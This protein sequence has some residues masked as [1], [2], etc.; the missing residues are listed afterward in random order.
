M[1]RSITI[2]V[3][4]LLVQNTA[5]KAQ[6]IKFFNG[7]WEEAKAEAKA[8]GKA[9][10]VDAYTTWCGPC[11]RMA[12]TVFTQAS[13]GDYFNE[14]FVNVKMDMEKKEGLKFGQKYPVSAYPTLYF[15]DADGKVLHKVKGGQPADKF[16]SLGKFVNS[17]MD[18]SKDYE[19]D[20]A[21]GKREPAFVLAYVKALNKAGKSSLKVANDY[22]KGQKDLNTDFNLD[23]LLHATT[24]ADSR[25]F[26]LLIK[27]RDQIA[28]QHEP[29]IVEK[30]IEKACQK[31]AAKAIE[32]ESEDL[33]EEAKQKMK[34]HLPA[35][36]ASFAMQADLKYYQ[37][38]K[39]AKAFLK[40]SNVFV[41]K[42]V[43]N[44]AAK[45]N[46]LATDLFTTFTSDKKAMKR[47]EQYAK[48][49]VANGGLYQYYQTYASIL[50]KNGKHEAALVNAKKAFEL[51]GKD[52]N[53]K[54]HILEL[55]RKIEQ[56]QKA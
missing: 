32:F 47:A 18:K 22:L 43:K 46:A 4:A 5:V 42:E 21:E 6:G 31:T 39:N 38:T 53:A 45:L 17:K 54:D 49:A 25:I 35:K 10:F 7:S 8:Q 27:H 29:S 20:Y 40:A 48:K 33:H 15:I 41:K 51:T 34:K 23:F 2:L 3:L 9:I 50:Y 56:K 28:K 52:R 19:K 26:D 55:I 14:N 37:A 11:K 30:T 24:E 1:I 36:S 44:N 12:K 13:V 16:V